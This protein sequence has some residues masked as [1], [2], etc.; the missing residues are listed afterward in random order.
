MISSRLCERRT[1]NLFILIEKRKMQIELGRGKLK[2]EHGDGGGE[3]SCIQYQQSMG[4][5][6]DMNGGAP[7]ITRQWRW[8][9]NDVCGQSFILEIT[10]VTEGDVFII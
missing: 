2:G 10:T 6:V 1:V 7:Y 5:D 8:R 9:K 4:N 3:S